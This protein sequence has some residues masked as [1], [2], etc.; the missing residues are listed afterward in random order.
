MYGVVNLTFDAIVLQ[1][2]LEEQNKEVL[3]A[4]IGFWSVYSYIV[5]C[6]NQQPEERHLEAHWLAHVILYQKEGKLA[7]VA[8]IP[9]G[10]VP[11]HF[12]FV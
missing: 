9:R 6:L 2:Q 7:G 3:R 8:S 11:G 4:L 12:I 5:N 10:F 1:K